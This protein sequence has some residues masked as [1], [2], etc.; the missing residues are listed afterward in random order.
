MAT[1]LL[2]K[3]IQEKLIK[4]GYF[5][6]TCGKFFRT[7]T[8]LGAKPGIMGSVNSAGY[9]QLRISGYIYLQSHL[10]TLWFTGKL[11]AIREEIDH[12]DGNTLNDCP[13]NLR[14]VS[15]AINSRNCKMSKRNTSGFTG[16]VWHSIAGK[17][18]SRLKINQKQIYFGLFNT[19]KEAYAAR[20]AY[21]EAH[22]ELG[23]TLRHGT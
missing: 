18:Q 19:A 9:R 4:W 8:S 3:M 7:K 12:I 17:W 23:F 21:I 2:E 13:E 11:P 15:R 6:A 16:V 5:N 20:Q 1:S 14:I 10:V 22:P